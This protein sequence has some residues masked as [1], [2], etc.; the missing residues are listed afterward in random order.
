MKER[1]RNKISKEDWKV[2]GNVFSAHSRKLLFKM[3]SQGYFEDL[4]AAISVGKEANVFTAITKD[5]ERIVAKIYR[6]ENCNFSKMYEYL[7]SDPRYVGTS[8]NSRQIIFTW[9]QREFRNL[10]IARD[11]IKVPKPIAFKDNV[12]L[13]E[14]IGIHDPASELKDQPPKDPKRFFKKVIDNMH[15]L[16]GVGLIHGDLSP[17]NILNHEEDPVFI[18]FSQATMKTASNAQELLRRDVKNI[19]IYFRKYFPISEIEEEK[20]YKKIIK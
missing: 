6:L 18:D 9:V 4:E 3:S 12:I 15:K 11:V 8:K 7:R 13:M 1:D 17:F 5:R 14:F 20:I 10:M 2:Y 16:F 19:C